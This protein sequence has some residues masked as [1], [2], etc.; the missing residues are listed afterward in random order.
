MCN[1]SLKNSLE[2]LKHVAKDHSKNITE[3]ISVKEKELFE[4]EKEKNGKCNEQDN[5]ESLRKFRCFKCKEIVSLED[6]FNDDLKEYQ[7]CKLCLKPME[8]N[9]D[10]LVQ[11]QRTALHRFCGREEGNIP[12]PLSA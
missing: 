1:I 7:M 4:S 12:S 8:I 9:S 10:G 3:N 5:F 2:V 11:P 6:K